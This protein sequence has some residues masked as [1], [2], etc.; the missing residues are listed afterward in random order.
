MT[1]GYDKD[2]IS[3]Q[4]ARRLVD[5]CYAAQ[6]NFLEFSQEQVDRICQAM[7]DAAYQ[8]AERLGRMA[9]EE[10]SYG[11]PVH[12]TL[13]NQLASRGVWESIKALKTVGVIREDRAQGLVEIGWPMGVV[14]AL[15]PSTNPTSTL[16]H[17]TL[18]A[19]KARNGIVNAPHPSAWRCCGEAAR[20]MADAG[21]AAGMPAG[22]VGCMSTISLPGTQELMRHNQTAVILATGGSDM[23]RAAHSMGKPAYGVGPGNVPCYVDR[24]AD[25]KTAASLIVSSKA[26]DCSVICATEQAVVADKPIAAALRTEMQ[27]L[28]ALFVDASQAEA[29]SR[30]LFFPNGAINPRSVGQTPQKLAQMANVRIPAETRILVAPLSR[31]GPEEPLSREKLTTVLGWYEVD[32]WQ[33]GCARCIEMI[34]FGGRGHSLVIH[35]TDEQVIMAFALQKP[36]FRL[37]ANTMG[38]LG[39]VGMTTG[40]MPA[41]TLGPGGI[42]GAISGDNITATHLLNVKRLAYPIKSPPPQAMV[43]GAAPPGA[44]NEWA[45]DEI[46][47]VVRAVVEELVRHGK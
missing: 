9:T 42:G 46:K 26:F 25:V 14:A 29:L 21:E 10:T 20:V 35:A 13:K 43:D 22:L 4:E 28:G 36:V 12:K 37:L 23:V 18:I 19:V 1:Q 47:A 45:P 27:R 5:G 11:I 7:A 39:A 6:Q 15:S 3:I 17:N 31:V 44:A 2:L 16:I 8:A 40:L 41:M 24:S 33:A 32:G 30:V 34:L 38:T